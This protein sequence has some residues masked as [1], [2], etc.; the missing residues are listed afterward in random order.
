MRSPRPW[1]TLAVLAVFA[2]GC[3]LSTDG[4]EDQCP[5]TQ[6]GNPSATGG[7][8]GTVTYELT[9]DWPDGLPD[10]VV[11]ARVALTAGDDPTRNLDFDRPSLEAGPLGLPPVPAGVGVAL[12]FE[13]LDP[14]NLV[15]FVSSWGTASAGQAGEQ[16]PT[17]TPVSHTASTAAPSDLPGRFK[18][19]ATALPDGKILIVGGFNFEGDAAPCMDGEAQLC[20]QASAVSDSWLFDPATLRA[21]QVAPLSQA[22][23]GH[24]ATLLPDGRVVI[25]GGAQ[26]ASVGVSDA[27]PLELNFQATGILDSVEIYSPDLSQVAMGSTL[28]EPR[29]DH[30]ARFNSRASA[31]FFWGGQGANLGQDGLQIDSPNGPVLAGFNNTFPSPAI[32]ELTTQ[33]AES[34]WLFGGAAPEN[35]NFLALVFPDE[36]AGAAN[37]TVGLVFPNTSSEPD[38]PRPEYAFASPEAAAF[39]GRNHA[40]VLGRQGVRCEP[41]GT[42][43]TFTRGADE[44][45]CQDAGVTGYI[46]SGEE[47]ATAPATLQFDHPG[48]TLTPL[49]DG[50]IVV[51]GGL[52]S[53]GQEVLSLTGEGDTAGVDSVS[54]SMLGERAAQTSTRLLGSGV[55]NMGGLVRQGDN[56]LN[57]TPTVELRYF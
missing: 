54:S 31:V 1:L 30:V 49:L 46:V 19:T 51:S 23:A 4:D 24:T 50:R 39:A 20:R 27:P 56:L 40:L 52:G 11:R 32:A 5:V 33:S 34:V 14:D 42:V 18:H 55:V 13:A 15:V 47:G 29:F 37:D 57:A 25:A 9:V 28:Q 38:R 8:V 48:G 2:A 35:N 43:P 44:V 36:P 16:Q 6:T 7:C 17:V 53:Q 26:S 45:L 3:A 12:L 22:R 21:T 41:G 10:N